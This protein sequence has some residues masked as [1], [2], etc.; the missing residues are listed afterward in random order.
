MFITSAL[1]NRKDID[2]NEK[3]RTIF[4]FIYCLLFI[5]DFSVCLFN[6]VDFMTRVFHHYTLSFRYQCSENVFVNIQQNKNMKIR[7]LLSVVEDFCKSSPSISADTRHIFGDALEARNDHVL[8]HDQ[9]IVFLKKP[10]H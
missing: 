4:G 8:M 1:N 6:Y 9:L 10:L 7:S 2:E 3:K 5:L